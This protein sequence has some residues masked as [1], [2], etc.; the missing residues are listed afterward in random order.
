MISMRV[1]AVSDVSTMKK[2]TK[3]DIWLAKKLKT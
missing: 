3:G 1:G 2:E